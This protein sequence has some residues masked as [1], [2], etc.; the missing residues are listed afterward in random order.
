M[1]CSVFISPFPQEKNGECTI[2]K[3]TQG[4]THNCLRPGRTETALLDGNILA[5]AWGRDAE[6]A[7]IR[8]AAENVQNRVLEP[9]ELGP[10]AVPLASWEGSDRT[11]H[12]C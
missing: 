2:P 10:M 11:G 8:A 3:G 9:D 7:R 1:E 12:S 4:V 6:T 5:V